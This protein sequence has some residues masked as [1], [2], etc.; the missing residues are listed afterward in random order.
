MDYAFVD[1]ILW[2]QLLLVHE[3]CQDTHKWR[4]EGW[5]DC[6]EG[7]ISSFD[8]GGSMDVSHW[9]SSTDTIDTTSYLYQYYGLYIC[10]DLQSED[11]VLD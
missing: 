9:I 2:T 4:Y 11:A 7:R 3:D 1:G 8:F 5:Q 10:H 6:E